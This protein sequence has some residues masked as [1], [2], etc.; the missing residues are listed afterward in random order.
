MFD[1]SNFLSN[2]GYIKK[3]YSLIHIILTIVSPLSTPLSPSHLSS[4][5]FPVNKTENASQGYQLNMA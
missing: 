4:P 2:H 1:I 5:P 3:K